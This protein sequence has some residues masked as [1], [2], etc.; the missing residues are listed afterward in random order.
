M[1]REL[2]RAVGGRVREH[3]SGAARGRD[4]RPGAPRDARDRRAVVVKVQRPQA[5]EVLERPAPARA[6]RR[7][8]DEAARRLRDALDVHRARRPPRRARC[9]ASSTSAARPTT[10]S[11]CTSCSSRSAGST[12]RACTGSCSSERLLV[13][14]AI[15]GGPLRDAP[16]GED[17]VEAAQPAARVLLR[18]GAGRRLLP[19][20]SRT[21]ATCC[22]ATAGST[23]STS[24]W[25]ASS[26]ASCAPR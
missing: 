11:G 21:R 20:R 7:E 22:G 24:G 3:R 8:G 18:A 5:G 10:S 26:T 19:C 6:V 13:M 16:E 14:E 2:R 12:C 23:S 9:A 4:D 25:S 1:E 17:R 15:D